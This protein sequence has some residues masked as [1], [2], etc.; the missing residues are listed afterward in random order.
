MESLIGQFE[1]VYNKLLLEQS[2]GKPITPADLYKLDKY[3][4]LQ[5]QLQEALQ[6]LGD[7]SHKILSDSFQQQYETIYKALP[8]GD[9]GTFSTLDKE[10]A[11]Q[12]INQIWCA[13]GKS[14]SQ[15]IWGNTDKLQQALNDNLIEC[16]IAGRKPSALKEALVREFNVAYHRADSIIR[17]ELAHIQ[18]ESAKKRYQDSGITQVEIWASPNERQCPECRK[19]HKKRFPIGAEPQVPLHPNCAC[20]IIPVID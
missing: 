5:G 1:I 18:T 13:D 6:S 17:T 10:A 16:V 4:K 8:V 2:E 20:C 3:W 7:K 14:W 15:R 12:V 9:S 19:L 11:Q